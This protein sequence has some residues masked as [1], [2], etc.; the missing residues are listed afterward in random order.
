MTLERRSALFV[1]LVWSLVLHLD[2]DEMPDD[3]RALL[4]AVL[5]DEALPC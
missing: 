3:E 1:R 4:Q 2:V 5:D